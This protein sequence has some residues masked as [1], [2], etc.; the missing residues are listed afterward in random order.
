[1]TELRL[2]TGR[3]RKPLLKK[4][5]PIWWFLNDDEE[6]TAPWYQPQW[7]Q[8]R[9]DFYWNFLRNPLQNFRCYVVGVQDRNSSVWGRKPVMTVQRN[10]LQPPEFGWQWCVLA[11]GPLR[12]PFVSYSGRCVVWYLG[13][14][15]S[16]FFGCKFNLH[17]SAPMPR[18]VVDTISRTISSAVAASIVWALWHLL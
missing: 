10:D 5:N 4:L 7:P 18:F 2:I 17:W 3:T 15:P 12:L 13:W 6:Q 9:R 16:G 14:Q 11:V 8:W 1:M